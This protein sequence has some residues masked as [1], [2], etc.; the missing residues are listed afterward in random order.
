[1]LLNKV[2]WV[3][4]D[5]MF[6]DYMSESLT[7][8]QNELIDQSLISTD[9]ILNFVFFSDIDDALNALEKDNH[10]SSSEVGLLVL[11]H[12]MPDIKGIDLAR[13][14]KKMQSFSHYRFAMCSSEDDI[15]VLAEALRLGAVEYITKQ[16]GVEQ[17]Y[18]TLQYQIQQINHIQNMVDN[19]RKRIKRALASG[20]VASKSAL[21]ADDVFKNMN[22]LAQRHD[23]NIE[24]YVEKVVNLHNQIVTVSDDFDKL[25]S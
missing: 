23:E 1:M 24:S 18:F 5:P 17:I 19:S 13:R 16:S 22:T 6:I 7:I 20:I 10:S 9:A 3:D 8:V 2:I 4:D 11:D 21:N 14:V 12:H 15:R 25:L